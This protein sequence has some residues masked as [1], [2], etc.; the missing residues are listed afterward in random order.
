[1]S[2]SASAFLTN[3]LGLV[4]FLKGEQSVSFIYPGKYRIFRR[5]VSLKWYLPNS[6]TFYNPSGVN[7][8]ELNRRFDYQKAIATLFRINGGKAGYYLFNTVSGEGWYCGEDLAS[9]E[10][11][12]QDLGDR[13]K[14]GIG[15]D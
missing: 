5:D 10:R 15:L 12:L 9:V 8:E 3:L 2:Q 6:A 4:G 13:L 1:M 14:P 11:K 7:V